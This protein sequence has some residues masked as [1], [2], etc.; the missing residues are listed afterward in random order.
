[1]THL[2]NFIQTYTSELPKDLAKIDVHYWTA[3]TQEKLSLPFTPKEVE[4]ALNSLQSNKSPGEDGFPPEFYREFKDVLIPL[5]MDTINLAS[6]TRSLP[7]SFSTAIITVIHKKN[8]D[9]LKCS[10]YRPI[11]LLNTD[12]KLI[13]KALVK[14][15]GQYLPQLINPD[16]CGFIQKRLSSNNLCHLFNIIHQSL[17]LNRALL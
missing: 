6:R 3:Q 16:Q 13:S 12:Y 8:K 1:M 10:S 11:S 4:K 14:R 9:P 7:E 2:S 15:L 17:E 5:I